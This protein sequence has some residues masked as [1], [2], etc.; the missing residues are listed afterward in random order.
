MDARLEIIDILRI[1]IQHE[2]EAVLR[3]NG[4]SME[5]YQAVTQNYLLLQM[6]DT[7]ERMDKTLNLIAVYTSTKICIG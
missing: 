4:I 6:L 5:E 3:I 2:M 7:L 1:G